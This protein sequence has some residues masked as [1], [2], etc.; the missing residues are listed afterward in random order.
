MCPDDITEDGLITLLKKKQAVGFEYAYAR[1]AAALFG[2]ISRIVDRQTDADK[3]LGEVFASICRDIHLYN[4]SNGSL[5]GWMIKTTRTLAI[6]YQ[7]VNGRSFEI[8]APINHPS[9]STVY[10]MAAKSPFTKLPIKDC[11]ADLDQHCKKLIGISYYQGYSIQ[12]IARSLKLPEELVKATIYTSFKK[13]KQH[14]HQPFGPHD[15]Q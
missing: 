11:L 10:T 3:L 1:Y 13:L 15:A 7:D 6:Q 14:I 5:F 4:P 12:E 9:K 2:I 8:L